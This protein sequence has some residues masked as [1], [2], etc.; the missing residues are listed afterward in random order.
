M[1]K[2]VRASEGL[3]IGTQTGYFK[4]KSETS[5]VSNVLQNILHYCLCKPTFSHV[6]RTIHWWNLCGPFTGPCATNGTVAKLKKLYIF[7]SSYQWARFTKFGCLIENRARYLEQY[8]FCFYVQH[9]PLFLSTMLKLVHL[10]QPYTIYESGCS[11]LTLPRSGHQTC[12]KIT[13]AECTVENSWWWAEKM[14]ETRR[15]L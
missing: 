15:I 14:P 2:T 5:C 1:Y 13:S 10:R 8:V 12:M 4:F 11:I 7:S 6:I 9:I 3:K